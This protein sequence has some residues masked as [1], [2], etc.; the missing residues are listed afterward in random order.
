MDMNFKHIFFLQEEMSA[1]QDEEIES[2]TMEVEKMKEQ[3]ATI[4]NSSEQFKTEMLEKFEEVRERI[5]RQ[6]ER[7]ARQEV[8]IAEQE[9]TILR[10][11]QRI[12]EQ[13]EKIAQMEEKV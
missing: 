11:D 9:Q 13:E 10:Q 2:L 5:G 4:G 1:G 8:Q 7:I 6:E 3:E 12:L